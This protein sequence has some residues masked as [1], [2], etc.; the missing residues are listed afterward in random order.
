MI[1]EA[2]FQIGKN[3]IND[4][5]IASLDLA[6]KTHDQIRISILKSATR[7]KK[8]VMELA[9]NIQSKLKKKTYLR[10]IGYTV[11]LKKTSK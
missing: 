3:P 9:T 7:D 6:F 2:K 11:I 10:I 4:N 1:R 5:F 8:Q